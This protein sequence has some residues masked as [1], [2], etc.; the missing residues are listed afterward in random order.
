MNHRTA[1][2]SLG[3]AALAGAFLLVTAGSVLAQPARIGL[4]IGNGAYSNLPALPSCLES[5]RQVATALRGLGFQVVERQDATSGG[6]AAAIDEFA[7]G[8]TATPDA[9]TFVYFC[10]YAAGMNE[11][12][13]LLP[14][15]AV[16]RRPTDVMTQGLLAKAMLD[17]MGRGKPSRGVLAL[18]LVPAPE[19]PAPELG[20]LTALPAPDGVGLV[21]VTAPPPPTGATALSA[22]LVEGLA[23]PLVQS[24]DLLE[25]L[26][27]KLKGSS[28]VELAAL[29]MPSKSRRL[30]AADDPPAPVAPPAASDTVSEPPDTGSSTARAATLRF[31]DEGEMAEV[32][33]RRVQESLARL[34]YY[35]SA[36]DGVFGPET[37]AAI[38]RFQH[39]IGAER[40]GTITGEQAARLVTWK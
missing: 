27:A 38:R 4:V 21:A 14:M 11:R 39:E 3:R 9:S 10:G 16:I 2:T 22:A 8:M 23:A 34:G 37:R 6:L 1:I 19:L 30:A 15:S 32:D 40:T 25:N 28:S 26:E 12:P 18:D 5:S 13:F 31:P 7:R 20:S 29:R 24:G 36:I 17:V 35:G 33:R